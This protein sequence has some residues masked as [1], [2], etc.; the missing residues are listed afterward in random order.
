ME[1][2]V[3]DVGYQAALAVAFSR[4]CYDSSPASAS[5]AG[6]RKGIVSCDTVAAPSDAPDGPP[7][8]H[9]TPNPQCVRQRDHVTNNDRD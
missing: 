3:W 7:L 5:L 9:M 6:W 8:N 2:G 4:S 1:R